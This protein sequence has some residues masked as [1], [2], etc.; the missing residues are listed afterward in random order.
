MDISEGVLQHA[1]TKKKWRSLSVNVNSGCQRTGKMQ[2]AWLN[3]LYI[4]A[5]HRQGLSGGELRI[6]FRPRLL[7]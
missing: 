2:P 5:S 6:S 3:A 4:S 7:C 1:H